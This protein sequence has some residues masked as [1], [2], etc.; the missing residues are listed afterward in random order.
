MPAALGASPWRSLAS[1]GAA[2]LLWGAPPGADPGHAGGA[3]LRPPRARRQ[4]SHVRDVRAHCAARQQLRGADAGGR[5]VQLRPH[6][7]AVQERDLPPA[8]A[9]R[10]IGPGQVCGAAHYYDYNLQK[11]STL[12]LGLRLRGGMQIF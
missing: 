4:V 3:E 5:A 2:C 12:Q 10:G 7:G 11:T 9:G 1:C 6:C 8:R